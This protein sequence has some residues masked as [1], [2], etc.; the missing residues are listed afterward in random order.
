MS[1]TDDYFKVKLEKAQAN[2]R[3]AVVQSYLATEQIK[4]ARTERQLTKGQYSY[5]VANANKSK[6][7]TIERD[8][9][10]LL[11]IN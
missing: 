6:Y 8:L 4:Y 5:I 1:D 10:V 7:A 2:Y 9:K 3:H 11:K